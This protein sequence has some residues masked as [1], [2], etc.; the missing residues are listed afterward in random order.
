MNWL[1]SGGSATWRIGLI[2]G[3]F[4]W[5]S[6]N[7]LHS[8]D[9][10]Q[11]N[12]CY[13]RNNSM[14]DN[15]QTACQVTGNDGQIWLLQYRSSYLP[16]ITHQ[17]FLHSDTLRN[18]PLLWASAWISSKTLR[19]ISSIDIKQEEISYKRACCRHQCLVSNQGL[20]VTGLL[21]KGVVD[22]SIEHRQKSSDPGSVE[23]ALDD[24]RAE[25][26]RIYG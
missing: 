11:A 9:C 23:A 4:F 26:L 6:S 25:A 12:I 13:L 17:L 19:E 24:I 2:I 1:E 3:Y 21:G 10:T 14:T 22:G 18:T 8:V 16:T 5:C 7:G 20:Q 15:P